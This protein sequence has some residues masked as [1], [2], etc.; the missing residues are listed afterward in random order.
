MF[1]VEYRHIDLRFSSRIASM[2]S[3]RHLRVFALY[4]DITPWSYIHIPVFAFLLQI[5][6]LIAISL[7][8]HQRLGCRSV[9]TVTVCLTPLNSYLSVYFVFISVLSKSPFCGIHTTVLCND[10]SLQSGWFSYQEGTRC[11]RG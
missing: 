3:E 5:V 11:L 1:R 7:V 8:C 9:T 6:I 4:S 10:G 2:S